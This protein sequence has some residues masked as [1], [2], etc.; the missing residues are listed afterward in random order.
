MQTQG[1]QQ[2]E[3]RWDA[4]VQS[5]MGRLLDRDQ[6]A[7]RAIVQELVDGGTDLRDIYLEL[8]QPAQ[9]EIGVLWQ[10]GRVTVAQEHYC[11]AVTQRIMS[12]LYPSVFAGARDGRSV[13]MACAG[14][15]LHELGARIVADFF[16]LEGWDTSFLGANVPADA[17]VAEVQEIDADLLGLSAALPDKVPEIA[18]IIE[19]VRR[20]VRPDLVVL[21]GGRPFLI[22][23]E[24]SQ[25]VGADGTA[26]D[27]RLAVRVADELVAARR[28]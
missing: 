19:E 14:G 5:Y 2:I 20:S 4:L 12:S 16:E 21:V 18:A 23:P 10:T 6:V 22:D 1:T 27:A 13:V 28:T 25:K 9:R 3:H 24:L 17:I 7:A 11:T 15:E 8:F 26:A